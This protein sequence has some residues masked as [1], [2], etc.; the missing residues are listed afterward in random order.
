MW[1]L[2]GPRIQSLS[3][4]LTGGFLTTGPL[5]K[6]LSM[7]FYVC[8]EGTVWA[9]LSHSY[10]MHLNYLRAHC[11]GGRWAL[12]DNGLLAST[13][14][15][16][17]NGKW[18]ICPQEKAY[19]KTESYLR[20]NVY[21][22]PSRCSCSPGYGSEAGKSFLVWPKFIQ[23]HEPSPRII[24]ELPCKIQFE[25]EFQV[26]LA[27]TLLLI[28]DPHKNLIKIPHCPLLVPSP[29]GL[30]LA[31]NLLA[32][33]SQNPPQTSC[34]PLEIYQPGN[35]LLLSCEYLPPG[36]VELEWR[37]MLGYPCL[38]CHCPK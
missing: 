33:F 30:P 12:V 32:W 13:G 10:D 31:Q 35:T 3:L 26:S 8:E 11:L 22:V 18:N 20:E 4:A 27:R 19:E 14:F 25:Q 23:A 36:S 16:Y 24:W 34:L 21:C 17:W 9:S 7:L 15:V 2:P 5:G 37:L 38:Y 29:V 28:Y 6:Y 1:D